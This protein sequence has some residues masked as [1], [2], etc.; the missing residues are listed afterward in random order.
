MGTD[1]GADRMAGALSAGKA[2]GTDTYG[3]M[4]GKAVSCGAGRAG[5]SGF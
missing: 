1:A 5:S 2:E 4:F 3:V